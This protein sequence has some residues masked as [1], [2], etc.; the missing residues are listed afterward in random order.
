MVGLR[1]W[2]SSFSWCGRGEVSVVMETGIKGIHR[3]ATTPIQSASES[4]H[5]SAKLQRTARYSSQWFRLVS[6]TDVSNMAG[7]PS[8]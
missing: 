2:A 1:S 6:H 5:N 7:P 4:A 8:R 3:P